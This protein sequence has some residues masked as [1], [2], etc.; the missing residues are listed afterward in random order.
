MRLLLPLV[1]IAVAG[2]VFAASGSARSTTPG[3][4]C[5]VIQGGFGKVTVTL[6]RGVV[7]GRFQSGTLTYTD[8]DGDAIANLPKVPLVIPAKIGDHK[9]Q[10]GPA[11]DVR[12]RA[13]GPTKLTINAQYVNLSV[14]GKGTAVLSTGGFAQDI[15]GNKFSVDAASFCEDNFQ[16]LPATPTKFS[17]SSPVAG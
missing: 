12:F 6:T 8:Q 15:P 2:G 10:Y 1:L 13:S 16:R 3:D 5:L 9:W 11:D 17:I 7:L 14:A 4:G